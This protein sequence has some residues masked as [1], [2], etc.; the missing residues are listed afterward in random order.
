MQP[1]HTSSPFRHLRRATAAACVVLMSAAHAGELKLAT[2][3]STDNSGLLKYL[4]PRF[5][6][7]SGV[8]V[9]VIAVGS[10]KAMKM[11]EMGDVDQAHVRKIALAI[12]E[13]DPAT[14]VGGR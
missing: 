8:S 5:E 6:Q 12:A 11:G 7:K 2:T 14:F 10:G 1:R 4:L 9:K 13:D 3:T